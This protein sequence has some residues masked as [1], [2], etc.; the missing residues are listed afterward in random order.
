MA[1]NISILDKII[2]RARFIVPEGSGTGDSD[3]PDAAIQAALTHLSARRAEVAL[4]A[5]DKAVERWPEHPGLWMARSLPLASLLRLR[6]ALESLVTAYHH[7]GKSG[8]VHRLL[9]ELAAFVSHYVAMSGVMRRSIANLEAGVG[10]L[11]EWRKLARQD[12][13]LAAFDDQIK[14]IKN[15]WPAEH[16]ETLAEVDLAVRL[17]SIEDPFEGWKALS[18]EISKRWPKDVSAVDAIREQR[19]W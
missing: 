2:E 16:R 17:Q 1:T 5:L 12:R 14:A 6:E 19:R 15:E 9:Y 18:K 4:R 11:I 13:Q 10:S 7:R 8:Q 3:G